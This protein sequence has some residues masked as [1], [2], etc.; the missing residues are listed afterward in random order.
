MI[1]FTYPFLHYQQMTGPLRCVI[2]FNAV[3]MLCVITF[4][5]FHS[6]LIQS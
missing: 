4:T 6:H 1:I 3:D 2:G 5:L